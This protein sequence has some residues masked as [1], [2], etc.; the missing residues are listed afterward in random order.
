MAGCFR[1]T[2]RGASDGG[3]K[4]RVSPGANFL[5]PSGLGRCLIISPIWYYSVTF[6]QPDGHR[7]QPFY[8]FNRYDR[9]TVAQTWQVLRAEFDQMLLD[10]AREIGAEVR[11]ETAVNRLLMEGDVVVGVEATSISSP[12]NT[13]TTRAT[14]PHRDCSSRATRSRFSIQSSAAA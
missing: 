2:L 14:A 13:A 3:P 11:E 10:N 12:A 6:V 9:E 8:F 5:Q 1:H 7:S 4:L